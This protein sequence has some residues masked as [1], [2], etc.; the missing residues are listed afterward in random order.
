MPKVKAK[1]AWAKHTVGELRKVAK[2]YKEHVGI[3]APSK[4]K[5]KDLI[6]VLDKVLHLDPESGM[7]HV[8]ATPQIALDVKKDAEPKAKKAAVEEKGKDEGLRD[9]MEKLKDAHAKLSVVFGE[10][11]KAKSPEPMSLAEEIAIAEKKEKPAV[12]MVK[13]K[14]PTTPKKSYA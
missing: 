1:Y 11:E 4:M 9:L 12:K 3:G 13:R 6:L 5:K 10:K 7:I 8:R 2:A 14:L